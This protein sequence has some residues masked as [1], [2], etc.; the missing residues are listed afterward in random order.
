MSGLEGL[1]LLRGDPHA[2]AQT[3]GLE[4]AHVDEAVHGPIR[5]GKVAGHLV[6]A[7]VSTGY[8]AGRRERLF[9]HC[10]PTVTPLGGYSGSK[11]AVH[12]GNEAQRGIGRDPLLPGLPQGLSVPRVGGSSPFVMMAVIANMILGKDPDFEALISSKV[13]QFIAALGKVDDS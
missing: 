2:I 6:D 13:S 9:I 1:D 10:W 11:T 5:D 12:N 3:H 7:E 8:E 4:I